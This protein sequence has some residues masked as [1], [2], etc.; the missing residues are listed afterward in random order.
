MLRLFL[1][2]FACFSLPLSAHAQ[3]RP[4][5]QEREVITDIGLYQMVPNPAGNGVIVLNTRTGHVRFCGVSRGADSS[6]RMFCT[7]WTR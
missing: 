5:V 3:Q 4:D 6:V 2:L 1:L 7:H